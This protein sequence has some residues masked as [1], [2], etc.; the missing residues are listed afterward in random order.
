M[1]DV[2]REHYRTAVSDLAEHSHTREADIAQLAIQMARNAPSPKSGD[3]GEEKRR[4]V[5]YYLV[6][7]G[8][9]L[10]RQQIRYRPSF[11]TWLQQFLRDNPDEVYIIGIEFVTLIT[12]AG[13]I[14]PF[15]HGRYPLT[16]LLLCGILLLI[17]VTQAAV[18]IL[19]YWIT[20]ILRPE[21]LPKFDFKDGVP[22]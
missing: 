11:D 1:D 21:P 13:I 18:E 16:M 4:H 22:P 9:R 14:L 5:G 6:D 20:S 8:L 17:P 19:N 2:T 3:R 12:I 7:R 10:L 15:S